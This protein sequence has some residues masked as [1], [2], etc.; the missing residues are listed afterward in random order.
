MLLISLL[1]SYVVG[2]GTPGPTGVDLL[3]KRVGFVSALVLKDLFHCLVFKFYACL[4][5]PTA[6]GMVR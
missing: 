5:L 6:L 3:N 1:N 4:N 2:H